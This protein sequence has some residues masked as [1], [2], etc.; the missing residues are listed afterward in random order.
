MPPNI[1]ILGGLLSRIDAATAIKIGVG[2][3][4]A[5]GVGVTVGRALSRKDPF[6][7]NI[8]GQDLVFPDDLDKYSISMAFDFME[9]ERR[10]VSKQPYMRPVGTIRLP[11]SKNITDAYHMSWEQKP[12]DPVVGAAIEGM[13]ES[14]QDISKA[15]GDLK[16]AAEAGDVTGAFG[17]LGSA[18]QSGA[19]TAGAIAA[20]ASINATQSL[21]QTASGALSSIG[22][23]SSGLSLGEVLQ[24]F[25]LAQNP[26]L[27]VLFK[28]PNFKKFKFNWRL[29]ARNPG[30][31]GKINSIINM[32]KFNML[33]TIA[34]GTGGTLL[35]Y[36]SMVNIAF[37]NS[38]DYL[39]RFKPCVIENLTV[40]YAPAATPSF[41]RG[42]ENV[43]TE[44]DLSV[45]LLEIE[46]WTRDDFSL[47]DMVP[48]ASAVFG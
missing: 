19:N 29:A 6:S 41:F 33:P 7:S 11:V 16:T 47:N 25:G 10:A 17:S 1:P 34:A 40:N 30:E 45:D 36:P 42:S 22:A 4:G 20:G 24:P 37:F 39:F 28:Q 48:G 14:K 38:D 12:Q 35:H 46:Y 31:S 32:F 18:F 21:L 5:V 27:T 2:L 44:I 23:M 9:Y 3:A 15:I 43:P 13:L 26:F 8:S